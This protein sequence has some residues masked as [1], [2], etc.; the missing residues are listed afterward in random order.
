MKAARSIHFPTMIFFVIFIVT[1]VAL[2]LLTGM[3]RNLNAMFAAQ[4]DVDPATYAT[5][6]TGTLVFLGALAVIALAWFAARPMVVAPL[7][8]L[9]GTV[10]NR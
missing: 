9:T 3:R 8:R 6:W 7:A 4:G 10:S 2:V 5:D 1:H